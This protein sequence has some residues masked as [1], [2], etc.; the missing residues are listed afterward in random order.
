MRTSARKERNERGFRVF[1]RTDSVS[2]VE[3][4]LAFEGPH[5]RIF[6]GKDKDAHV[7]LS[8]AD[9]RVV[10]AALSAFVAEA[11]AGLLAEP[12]LP[13]GKKETP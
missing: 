13:S 6:G 2:V 5:C 3:S 10:V 4:S 11:K 8:L 7:H 12:P 1:G 9:A